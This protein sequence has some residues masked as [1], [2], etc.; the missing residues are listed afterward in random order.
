MSKM[1]LFN[2][3]LF[4]FSKLEMTIV[5]NLMEKLSFFIIDFEGS[6][7]VLLR[8]KHFWSTYFWQWNDGPFKIF[9]IFRKM[10]FVSLFLLN[11]RNSATSLLMIRLKCTVAHYANVNSSS[12]NKPYLRG[13][14]MYYF[15]GFFN[16]LFMFIL[17]RHLSK[18]LWKRYHFLIQIFK[19]HFKI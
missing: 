14:W 12:I 8:H 2:F 7:E 18:T 1:L 15:V 9:E 3:C 13:R 11:E 6:Y 10:Y 5:K 16:F 4:Y 19:T 17:T